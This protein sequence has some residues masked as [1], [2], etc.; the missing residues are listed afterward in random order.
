MPTTPLVFSTITGFILATL[1]VSL[2]LSGHS[3][4]GLAIVGSGILALALVSWLQLGRQPA[5][6]RIPGAGVAGHCGRDQ[7]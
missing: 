4:W 3:G 1:G 5:L 6:L 2:G 7:D